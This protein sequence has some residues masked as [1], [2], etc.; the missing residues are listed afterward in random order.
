[1]AVNVYVPHGMAQVRPIVNRYTPDRGRVVVVL[2]CGVSLSAGCAY[3]VTSCALLS[4][5][6]ST[7]NMMVQQLTSLFIDTE[8]SVWLIK[9]L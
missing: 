5:I 1:M 6:R 4:V 8:N 2:E 7:N 9:E 3:V